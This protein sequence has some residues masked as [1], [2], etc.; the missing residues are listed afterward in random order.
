MGL[1]S[2]G[3]PRP[4]MLGPLALDQ[5]PRTAGHLGLVRLDVAVGGDHGD[6]GVD[7][8]HQVG[9]ASAGVLVGRLVEGLDGQLDRLVAGQA[10]AEAQLDRRPGVTATRAGGLVVGFFVVAA[11][12]VVGEDPPGRRAEVVAGE[13]RD[14]G[15]AL[16]GQGQV[17]ADH[18]GQLVGLSLQAQ[19]EPFN[20]LVVLE[21]DLEQ[22]DHLDGEAGRPGD[23]H[24]RVA[25]GREHLLHGPVG[26][27]VALGRPPVAGHHDPV[28]EAQGDN[29][30][31]VAHRQR[32]V[33]PR[34]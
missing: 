12:D 18:L 14:H 16:H 32:G 6:Q 21:L 10:L 1:T 8:P 15:Q 4:E 26:D 2:P 11:G 3:G 5:M 23:G 19:G 29:R 30:G 24:G 22:A 31:G 34:R 28:G 33:G 20:L 25:V 27:G 7:A 9:A 17:G 13:Q